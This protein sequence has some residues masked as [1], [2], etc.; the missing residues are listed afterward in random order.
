MPITEKTTLALTMRP[1][2]FDTVIGL[3]EPVRIIRTKIDSGEIPRA[4]L[5]RGPYGTGKT[6][7]AHIIAKYVQ[8]PFFEGLPSVHEVNGANYRKIEN[9]RALSDEA[10]AYPMPPSVYHVII[11]D[12]C[13][14][15]TG[16][17]QDI[18]LKELEVPRSSTIWI[19]ATTDPED[20]NQGVRDRC[21][22]LETSGMDATQRHELIQRAVKTTGY[23]DTDEI[24][25]FE[26]LI[27]KF[28]INSPRRV[29]GAFELM[30]SGL[31]VESAVAGVSINVTPEYH[32]IAF[33]TLFGQWDKDITLWGK[34][35]V[36]AVGSL[37]R[38]L[39]DKLSKKGKS[40]SEDEEQRVD[41]TDITDS[42]PQAATALRAVVG[43]FLKGRC[44]PKA[45]KGGKYKFPTAAESDRAY[46]AMHVLANT[47]P[48]SEF[49]L[50]W[51]GIAV[52]LYRVNQIM[53]GK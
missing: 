42:K 16:D 20:L 8:G 19:L 47:V 44:V 31:N 39:E 2:E 25:N 30:K 21:F 15:L 48:T 41:D 33:A 51:S 32:D 14:K 1:K 52:T 34:V 35:P 5:I 28:A 40:E 38:D 27:T 37:F 10:G 49:A 36:R 17:S 7:L 12:E 9:M 45:L 18:L 50:Q 4:I 26:A 11:I 29:L 53:Q 46:K 6:T 3:E 13:H 43:A 24:A 23:G 22:P